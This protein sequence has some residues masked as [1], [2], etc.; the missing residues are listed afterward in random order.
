VS[1]VDAGIIMDRSDQF[2]TIKER[3]VTKALDDSAFNDVVMRREVA[4]YF[5]RMKDV[6]QSRGLPTL[7]GIDES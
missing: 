1:R 5:Y 6:L 2:A 3:A 7:I 4:L